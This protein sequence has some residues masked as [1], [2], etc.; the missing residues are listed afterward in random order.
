MMQHSYQSSI[1]QNQGSCSNK[2]LPGV[3]PE[4]LSVSGPSEDA[5][6]TSSRMCI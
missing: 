4:T 3:D 2:T 5:R 6:A 1:P